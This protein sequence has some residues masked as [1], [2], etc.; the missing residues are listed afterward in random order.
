MYGLSHRG[1]RHRRQGSGDPS[2]RPAVPQ[3]ASLRPGTR[4]AAALGEPAGSVMPRSGTLQGRPISL[5]E[6]DTG[7]LPSLYESVG[8]ADGWA[9]FIDALARSYGGGRGTLIVHEAGAEQR[10]IIASGQWEPEQ[11]TRYNRYYWRDQSLANAR[12]R[13]Q[14][15]EACRRPANGRGQDGRTGAAALRTCSRPSTTTISCGR[16]RSTAASA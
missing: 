8:K 10:L 15:H 9:M 16:Q 1:S 14:P 12:G 13:D 7:L 3:D 4:V 11:V 5:V 6:T 2:N